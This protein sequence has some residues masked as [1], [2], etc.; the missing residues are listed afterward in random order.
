MK[1][2]IIQ[3]LKDG[4]SVEDIMN[5]LNISEYFWRKLGMTKLPKY[6]NI[7]ENLDEISSY[8]LGFLWADG[9]LT[10]N[11]LELEININDL[12]HLKTFTNLLAKIKTPTI[13]IRNRNNA[14][15][16][17]I[18]IGDKNIADSLRSLGFDK[19]GKRIKPEISD[20]LMIHFIRGYFDGDGSVSIIQNEM[21]AD[22]S[23]P[24]EVIDLIKKYLPKESN[25]EVIINKSWTSKRL[26]WYSKLEVLNLLQLLSNKSSIK[27]ERKYTALAPIK[28]R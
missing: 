17:R 26:Y 14:T 8:W 10:K 16:C 21:R 24:K 2:E 18:S 19:K 3:L 27:L 1:E 12:D 22:L 25:S 7:F 20:D 9:S 11:T 23:G 28:L 4:K 6:N 15:T 13:H 5:S